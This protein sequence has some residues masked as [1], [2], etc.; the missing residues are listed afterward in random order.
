MEKETQE[1][2]EEAKSKASDID[3]RLKVRWRT[4]SR[5]LE[6]RSFFYRDWYLRT[7]GTLGNF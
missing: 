4:H 7:N 3:E 6:S 1:E 2:L 5:A